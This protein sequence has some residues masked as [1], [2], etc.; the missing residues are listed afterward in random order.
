MSRKKPA[1]A[2]GNKSL[3]S[4][5]FR[6]LVRQIA[7]PVAIVASGSGEGRNAQTLTA[8]CSAGAEPPT[9]LVCINPA[10]PMASL[11]AESGSFSVNF[12]AEE[13]A[14]LARM[15][16]EPADHGRTFAG[17]GSWANLATGSPV[18]SDAAI[19]FDCRLI[20]DLP[21]GQNRIFVGSVAAAGSSERSPLLYRN[22]FFHRLSDD[23]GV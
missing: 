15:F 22:G 3:S 14:G 6:S 17:N 10:A 11:I 19:A 1:S 5:R 8:V 4:H 2:R 20:A 7:S 23:A 12:L 13:Q 16:S 21:C 9:V 18:L